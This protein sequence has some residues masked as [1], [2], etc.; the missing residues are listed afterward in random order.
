MLLFRGEAG[1]GEP[2]ELL[3]FEYDILL[4]LEGLG[5]LLLLFCHNNVLKTL[6]NILEQTVQIFFAV[7]Q[8]GEVGWN[9]S[10][11]IIVVT[12][13]SCQV[14]NWQKKLVLKMFSVQYC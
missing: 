14:I 6:S 4:L 12:I 8:S 13:K 10:L 9:V 3:S 2:S 5:T 1:S 11:I 7:L